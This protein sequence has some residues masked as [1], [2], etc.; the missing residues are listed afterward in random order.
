M[1]LDITGIEQLARK[2]ATDLGPAIQAGAM[3]IAAAIQDDLAP[4]PALPAR[5]TYRRTGQLGQGWRI[6]SIPLGAVLENRVGYSR[7]VH[8]APG[9]T[10]THQRTGWRDEQA[11]I[12]RVVG[13]GQAARL[14]EQAIWDRL[15]MAR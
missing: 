13:S 7:W 9:Q 3:G 1:R 11:A 15:G 6:R 4:Y 8:G 14:M 12:Q 5:S 10:K 2:L